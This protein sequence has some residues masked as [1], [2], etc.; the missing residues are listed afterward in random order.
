M[1]SFF[2]VAGFLLAGALFFVVPPLLGKRGRAADV[3]HGETNL[4]IYRDQLRELDQ[5][6]AN[7]NIE[8][9][10]YDAA[11]REIERRV[12]EEVEQEADLAAAS[13]GPKWT[14][15]V[16]IAVA[17]PLI[18]VPVYLGFGTPAALDPQKRAA[19]ETGAGHEL[20]P[21]RLAAMVEQLKERLKSQPDDAEGWMMLA[22]TTGAL[23]RYD[24]SA[25]AYRQAVRL[26]P[27]D[28]DLLADYADTLAMAQGR[29]LAGEPE[30]L[31]DQALK[32]DPKHVKSLALGGTIA[33]EKQDYKKA[34]TLW[35]RILE[36]V[37]PDAEFAER[38]RTSVA[39][40]ERK[41]GVKPSL[42]AASPAASGGDG[43]AA[44]AKLS[45]QVEI[46]ASAKKSVAPDDTVF[47]YARA[48]SG[49]K[50]PLAILRVQVKDLPK[51]FELT[52]AMAM[53]PG[54][55]IGKFPDLVVGARVSK[56][57]NAVAQ[58]GDWESELVPARAGTSGLKLT[59][60]RQVG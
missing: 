48:A 15:A 50:M 51:A 11:K 9:L 12:L 3:S 7:G 43:S 35:K 45:G 5:D 27:P 4:S 21:Q 28:A 34:A 38:I 40:A 8:R 13:G 22:K 60:A 25:N 47:I 41:S 29:S 30:R 32:V 58:P 6:L 42:A 2:V 55:S 26:V 57:G 37:P 18:A 17:I 31:I 36:V 23:G 16:G 24:D 14:L 20:T 44:G 49:P 10:Q 19:Q 54:M 56:S 52:E 1:I 33:F 39:E 46:A 53:A 59:I